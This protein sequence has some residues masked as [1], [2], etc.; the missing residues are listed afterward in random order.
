VWNIG[1]RSPVATVFRRSG[2]SPGVTHD[3]TS[4]PAQGAGAWTTRRLLGWITEALER[5]GVD[6]PRLCA[7]LLVS[8]VLGCERLRLYM[9]ADRPAT[10]PERERLRDLVARALRH[11]PVQRLVGEAWFYSLPFRIDER[12]MIPR[13]ST[14]TLVEI[15]LKRLRG[16]PEGAAPWLGEVG[17]GS[18]AVSVAILKNAPGARVVAG[19]V[20]PE[21]LSLARENAE[22]HGVADRLTLLEGDLLA[23]FNAWSGGR[24]LYALV[25]NPP[26]I[27]DDEWP[28]VPRNVREW[29]PEIALRGGADGLRYVRPLIEQGPGLIGPGGLLAIEVAAARADEALALA[30]SSPELIEPSIEKDLDGLPRVLAAT[31]R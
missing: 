1:C 6:S 13:P 22:R 21:A 5:A 11:E 2:Y 25:S 20:S 24:T 10:E 31:R 12:A 18:G 17:V 8:H 23:P 7:E 14:E 26:Y 16:L 15:A 28:D 19:D 27:P 9:E 29:D 3:P 30:E 4:A